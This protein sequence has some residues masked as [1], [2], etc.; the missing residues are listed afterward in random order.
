MHLLAAFHK[1]RVPQRRNPASDCTSALFFLSSAQRLHGRIF[2]LNRP[3]H[4]WANCELEWNQQG[5]CAR[6]NLPPPWRPGLLPVE[7]VRCC[8]IG[9]CM[10]MSICNIC[11]MLGH[12][13]CKLN[14]P[15]K[16]RHEI[17]QSKTR[18][19]RGPSI[20]TCP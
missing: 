10:C 15:Q 12:E 13:I 2:D 20:R 7:S 17:A 9:M 5:E 18:S 8:G 19:V 4:V 11:C 1:R 3:D 16:T 14:T 6:P